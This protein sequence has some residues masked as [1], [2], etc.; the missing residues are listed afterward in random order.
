MPISYTN[1]KGKTFFLAQGVT[2]TGKP[3]YFFSKTAAQNALEQIPADHHIEESVNG[4]VSLVKDRKQSSLPEEIKM[5]E[6]VLHRHPKGNNYRLAAKGNQITVYERMGSDGEAMADIFGETLPMYSQQNI[7][8]G[9]RAIVEKNAQYSPMLHFILVDEAARTFRAERVTYVVSLPKW[10][11]MSA[12]GPL[13][14]AVDEIIPLLNTD[15][16]FELR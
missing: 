11:S 9:M 7:L 6:A 15:E 12:C 1:H 2:K 16:Y 4:V 5:V 3:R 10:V 8:D 14:E 13:Q